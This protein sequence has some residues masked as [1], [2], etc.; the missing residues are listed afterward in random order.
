MEARLE[1]RGLF[2]AFTARKKTI[3]LFGKVPFSI[4][5]TRSKN[6]SLR[7]KGKERAKVKEEVLGTSLGSLLLVYFAMMAICRD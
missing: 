5:Q 4:Q 3:Y 7:I 2:N 1:F 6:L